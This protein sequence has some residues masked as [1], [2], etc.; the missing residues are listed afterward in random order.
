[1]IGRYFRKL[2]PRI[3]PIRIENLITQE[4]KMVLFD[5]K[6]NC[7]LQS[8]ETDATAESTYLADLN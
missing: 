2:Q 7:S 8:V 3:T 6:I 1:V 4:S 5:V